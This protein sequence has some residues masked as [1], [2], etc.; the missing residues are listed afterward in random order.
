M[1]LQTTNFDGS[2]GQDLRIMYPNDGYEKTHWTLVKNRH[3][4]MKLKTN[5]SFI[6]QMA[7][8]LNSDNSL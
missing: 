3:N 8:L 4:N 7:A 2:C 5:A 1:I 6:S